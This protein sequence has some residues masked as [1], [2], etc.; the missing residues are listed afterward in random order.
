MQILQRS[1]DTNEDK[2][3]KTFFQTNV[4]E[5]EQYEE[6]E[7]V[8]GLEDKGSAPF[9]TRAAYE[10]SLSISTAHQFVVAAEQQADQQKQPTV[11]PTILEEPE[12]SPYS[13]DYA[14]LQISQPGVIPRPVIKKGEESSPSSFVPLSAQVT[15]PQSCPLNS[16]VGHNSKPKVNIDH[17]SLDILMPAQM[18]STQI[19][20]AACEVTKEEGAQFWDSSLDVDC[21]KEDEGADEVS[22]SSGHVLRT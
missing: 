13:N 7:E 9:L 4:M 14:D 20:K 21:S 15:I 16:E 10:K 17:L 18:A 22:V 19:E 5:E 8:H 3:V 6:E 1:R 11:V 12:A 2:R